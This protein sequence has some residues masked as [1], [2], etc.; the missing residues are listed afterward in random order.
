[1]VQIDGA[2]LQI[3]DFRW[4]ERKKFRVF[5]NEKL[6]IPAIPLCPA[7]NYNKLDISI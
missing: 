5:I 1:M 7:K 4:K 3:A 2:Y 6:F